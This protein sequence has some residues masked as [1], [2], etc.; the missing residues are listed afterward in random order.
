[1]P[2][3]SLFRRKRLFVLTESL[4]YREI[5]FARTRVALSGV[6]SAICVLGL[7]LIGNHLSGDV[8]G[9]GYNQLS[10]LETENR[11]LKDQL[12]LLSGKMAELQESIDGIAEAGNNLRLVTDLE[13]IDEDTRNAGVGG[14]QALAELSYVGSEANEILRN[15]SSLLDQLSREVELQKMSYEAIDRKYQDNKEFFKRIPSIK[16]VRGAYSIRGF[17]MRVHPVLGIRRMHEGIDIITDVGTNIYASA[18]GVVRYAGRTRGGYGSVVEISHGYG[19]STL[20]A[21]VSKAL[22]RPGQTI[23]RGDLIAKSGRTGLVSGPHLHYEVRQSG[24]KMNPVDYFFD[25]VDAAT[26]REEL[27]SASHQ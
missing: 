12:T 27:E 24:R 20:Y 18:D 3:I 5:R 17:G 13:P 25:D 14:S 2:K 22:V 19:Y 16:P 21:H 8:L 1:L 15:S 23:R 7:L 6:V 11:I 9:V 4:E 10:L 26:Y